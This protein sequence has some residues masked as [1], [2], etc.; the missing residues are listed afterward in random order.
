MLVSA[1]VTVSETRKA[2][3]SAQNFAIAPEGVPIKD[4]LASVE[5]GLQ[6]IFPARLT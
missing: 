3:V 4:I 2:S 5:D 6:G 1:S